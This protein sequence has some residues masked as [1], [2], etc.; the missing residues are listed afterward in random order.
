MQASSNLPPGAH[1][2][3]KAG[4]NRWE[5]T[6][7]A[8]LTQPQ[9]LQGLAGCWLLAALQIPKVEMQPETQMGK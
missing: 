9:E 3:L 7:Q 5:D 6:L 4:L 8:P 1:L 2:V